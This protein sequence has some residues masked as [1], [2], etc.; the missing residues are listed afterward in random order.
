M[1]LRAVWLR[2]KARGRGQCPCGT[3]LLWHCCKPC[4]R[5]LLPGG[6]VG[7]AWPQPLL[8]SSALHP[9]VLGDAAAGLSACWPELVLQHAVGLVWCVQRPALSPEFCFL[10]VSFFI[11]TR[12]Y[13]LKLNISSHVMLLETSSHLVHSSG[14]EMAIKGNGSF[15]T[16]MLW[17]KWCAR[18]EI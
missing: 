8:L 6:D 16:L 4:C 9:D 10:L 15:E 18:T 2:A 14:S 13:F 5:E 3:A 17:N 7:A 12:W 11:V 1:A